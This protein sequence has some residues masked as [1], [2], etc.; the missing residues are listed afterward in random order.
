VRIAPEDY[1]ELLE[2]LVKIADMEQPLES[3][4]RDSGHKSDAD[5]ASNPEGEAVLQRLGNKSGW[6]FLAI[7]V[8]VVL[9]W[10]GWT[11]IHS[12]GEFDAWTLL[13]SLRDS[14]QH[15]LA[16]LL[17]IPAIVAGSLV[18]APIT[19]MIAL[20]ALLFSPWIASLGTKLGRA[21][22][23]HAP[24]PLTTRMHSLGNNA[25]A[26]SLAGLRLIPIAPFTVV[27]LLAGAFKVK[28]RDFVVGTLIGMGPGIVLICLSVDRARAALSGEPVFDPWIIGAIAVAGIALIGFR[29][30][31]HRKQA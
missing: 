27:N 12:G 3:L 22:E 28:L 8:L 19:G 23:K 24:K 26:W 14:A 20:C 29:V 18:V 13:E 7:I 11:A 4:W 30:W 31:Q 9:G 17:A 1:T 6:L 2:P 21:A 16:P 25:D 10:A 5:A 15:P